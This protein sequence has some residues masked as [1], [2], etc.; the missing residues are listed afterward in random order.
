VRA[1]PVVAPVSPQGEAEPLSLP[2]APDVCCAPG[3][4]PT[5]EPGLL[6]HLWGE[7][8]TPQGLVTL[9]V[10]FLNLINLKEEFCFHVC[11]LDSWG[12]EDSEKL[13]GWGAQDRGRLLSWASGASK[14]F[15][16]R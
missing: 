7:G 3:P 4:S 11:R 5:D 1:E 10:F 14:G 13:G 12:L 9:D 8:A 6:L 15:M 2:P 16:E